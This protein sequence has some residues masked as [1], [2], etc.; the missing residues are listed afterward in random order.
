M[1]GIV[2]GAGSK[3]GTIGESFGRGNV[4]AFA[5]RPDDDILLTIDGT[6]TFAFADTELDT[7]GQWDG[8]DTFTCKVPGLWLL[9]AN[10]SYTRGT[11]SQLD[12][13]RLYSHIELTPAASTYSDTSA[14]AVWYNATGGEAANEGWHDLDGNVTHTLVKLHVGQ[15]AKVKCYTVGGTSGIK[16]SSW[17]RFFGHLVG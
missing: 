1:S 4:P 3:S 7:D 12:Y 15:E 13:S 2:G 17:S 10:M 9:C 8:D 16:Y 14:Y 11:H 6:T 5:A